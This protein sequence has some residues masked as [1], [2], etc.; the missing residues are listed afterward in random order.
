[1][2]LGRIA[3]QDRWWYCESGRQARWNAFVSPLTYKLFQ[4]S[5]WFRFRMSRSDYLG[6]ALPI[7]AG[8]DL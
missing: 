3:S 2:S 1:M 4:L 5:E 8:Y 6:Y 7:Q